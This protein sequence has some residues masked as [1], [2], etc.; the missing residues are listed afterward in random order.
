MG[1]LWGPSKASGWRWDATGHR[2][3]EGRKG[4]SLRVCG[5]GKSLAREEQPS[6]IPSSR[7]GKSPRALGTV[8]PISM[9]NLA[10]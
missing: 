9:A 1:L 10:G 8:I 4:A 3:F 7:L 6:S 5:M 2:V